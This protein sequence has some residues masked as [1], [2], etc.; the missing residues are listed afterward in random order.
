MVIFSTSTFQFLPTGLHGLCF[1]FYFAGPL[2][3]TSLGHS[4]LL[5]VHLGESLVFILYSGI[6]HI[7]FSSEG[8][9]VTDDLPPLDCNIKQKIH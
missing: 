1:G 8:Q 3:Q 7:R 5:R 4:P 6:D 9:C 2:P